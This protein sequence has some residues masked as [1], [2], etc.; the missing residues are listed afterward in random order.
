MAGK[1]S[2]D[3]LIRGSYA[4]SPIGRALFVGLRALDPFLQYGILAHGAGSTLIHGLGGTVLPSGPPAHTGIELID[5]LRLSPYRL[6]LLA[7][8]IGSMLKQN[9]WAVLLSGDPI[10][11][12]AA[13]AIGAF[14]SVFNSLASLLAVCSATSAAPS[15]DELLANRQ[16]LIGITLYVTGI[17]LEW[18]SEIQRTSFKSN[19]NNKGKPYKGGLWSLARHINY[20]GYTLWRTGYALTGGGWITAT[21]VASFFTWDFITRA[22]PVLDKYCSEKA[23]PTFISIKHTELT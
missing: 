18:V 21:A 12:G 20:G 22:I 7:M 4:P 16:V 3:L 1:D 13:F 10:P 23:S 19:P 9:Y 15:G 14:N 8:S 11:I 6:T 2:R 5:S 17:F